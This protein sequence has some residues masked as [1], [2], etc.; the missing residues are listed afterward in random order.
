[1]FIIQN[2]NDIYNTRIYLFFELWLLLH[3]SNNLCSQAVKGHY[4]F[5]RLV[6]Y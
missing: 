5:M 1:M 3:C 2:Y 6:I 4:I